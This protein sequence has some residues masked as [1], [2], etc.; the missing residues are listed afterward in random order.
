[1]T[2]VSPA[3]P[4]LAAEDDLR[5]R[6]LVRMKVA[7]TSLLLAATL[8]F[9]VTRSLEDRWSWLGY[10]RAT[11]E[12]AMVGAL[13]DWFAVTALFRHPLGVPIPHTAII[14]NRKDQLGRGLG[15]FVQTNFLAPAVLSERLRAVGVAER[16]G[17][18]LGQPEHAHRLSSNA[19]ALIRGL[20]EVMGDE[21]IQRTLETGILQ[22]VR[23]VPAAPLMAR[24]VEAAVSGRH[25]QALLDTTL[26]GL[27]GLLDENRWLL[28]QKLAEQSPWWVPEPIDDRLFKKFFDGVQGFLAEVARDPDHELRHQ[29]DVRVAELAVR[30]RTDPALIARG[31]QLKAELLEHPEVRA[32]L[33]SLWRNAKTS[34]LAVADDPDS[35]LRRRLDAALLRAGRSLQED[36]V[37]QGKVNGWIEKVV[38][39]LAEEY[40]H[41]I[42]DLIATTVARWDGAEASRRIELQVGRDLQFI[43]I[44][45]TVVGGLA[46][47]VIYSVGRFL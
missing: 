21:D 17:A 8:V 40:G 45:G 26:H 12:A 47:L 2:T 7:A 15:T 16:L 31:E 1:M 25:H 14:P 29:L 24:V 22:R 28:R 32:W 37:L 6:N 46:G 19:G 3:L 5:R 34:I 11:A 10:V 36:P 9:I 42:A 30:L 18:W 33:D 44:N 43:R 35:D 38:G 41:E 39:Y 4:A 27:S 23:E 20:T 13:A